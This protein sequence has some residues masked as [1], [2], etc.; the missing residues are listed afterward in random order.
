MPL[1][2]E[3][4]FSRKDADS[5]NSEQSLQVVAFETDL[6]WIALLGS[7]TTLKQ[8]V[9]GY[10]AKSAA[11]AA[12]DPA[13]LAAAQTRNWCPSLVD[14]LLDYAAGSCA[15][16]RDVQLDLDHLT[17][18]QRKVVKQCR[19]IPYGE[20]RSYGEL[21][22]ESGSARAARAVGNTMATNRYALI[23]P[24]HRVINAD[25]GI[26]HFGAPEGSRM[27]ARLLEM[28]RRTRAESEPIQRTHRS[29]KRA[30]VHC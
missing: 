3:Q 15:D 1:A 20:T 23:V 26:G 13:R 8:L 11:L 10:R 4:S 16:F 17:P 2:S 7:G 9:F 12:L 19:A 6:G 28:E 14:R 30:A 22:L 18:F 29:A 27:K 24:C 25:G 5:M 21:A